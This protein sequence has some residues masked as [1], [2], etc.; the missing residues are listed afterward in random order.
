MGASIGVLKI[1]PEIS[2]IYDKQ[3]FLNLVEVSI[4]VPYFSK[5]AKKPE[6]L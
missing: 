5:V 1:V 2:Q 3:Y 4:K 6:V